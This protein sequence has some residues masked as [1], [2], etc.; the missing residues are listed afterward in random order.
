MEDYIKST[1]QKIKQLETEIAHSSATDAEKRNMHHT[2]SKINIFSGDVF[3]DAVKLKKRE[4]VL[5]VELK[6][7]RPH[8]E[9]RGDIIKDLENK[10][11]IKR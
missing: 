6:A 9:M 1:K 2:L 8:F 4:E 5:D 11:G 3:D 10:L 7:M